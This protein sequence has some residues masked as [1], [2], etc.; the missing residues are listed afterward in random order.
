S[1]QGAMLVIV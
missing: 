1:L